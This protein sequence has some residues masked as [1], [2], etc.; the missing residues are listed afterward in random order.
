MK[1]PKWAEFKA[2]ESDTYTLTIL[3]EMQKVLKAWWERAYRANLKEGEEA[4]PFRWFTISLG[5]GEFVFKG[6]NEDKRIVKYR[7]DDQPSTIE[8]YANPKRFK[9]LETI[10]RLLST[11]ITSKY[12]APHYGI[13]DY[14]VTLRF[15][16]TT[17]ELGS[18]KG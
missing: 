15:D 14:T 6:F 12:F 10:E 13:D 18:R 8:F 17:E 4:K 7:L 2:G 9:S 1:Y 5:N 3:P 16:L 11:E